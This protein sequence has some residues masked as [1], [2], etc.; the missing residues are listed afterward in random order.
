MKLSVRVT[1]ILLV[2]AAAAG[3]S[4]GASARPQPLVG[5]YEQGDP[6]T[7]AGVAKFTSATGIKPQVV[8]YYASWYEK[9]WPSF[10]SV[11]QRNG[12]IV[13]IQLDP[14]GTTLSSISEGKS[15][16]HL[17]AFA[18]LLKAFKQKVLI[19]FGHEMNGDWYPWGK[20]HESPGVYVA[21]W[22]HIVQVFRSVGATN[23]SWVWTISSLSEAP[24]PLRP[25]WPGSA[26]VN[27][28]GIDGYYYSASDTYNSVF[29]ST[30]RQIRKFT[31]VPVFI[32]EA[33]VGTNPNRVNQITALYADAA[34]GH[35]SG[36]VWFDVDQADGR[37][38]SRYR[39]DWR[40][41]DDPVALAAFKRAV[42]ACCR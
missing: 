19:S 2:I 26:W 28:V 10:A 37:Y 24:G 22:R 12:A 29:G 18:E 30:I 11:A 39:Q 13:L 42:D 15:D 38:R 7:W 40:L 35:V 4:A 3:C 23:V 31:E 41:E 1:A 32:T 20:G 21:A 14:K 9:F 5:V 8:V 17:T 6:M 16:R 27:F 25:W 34:A 36:I 33:G